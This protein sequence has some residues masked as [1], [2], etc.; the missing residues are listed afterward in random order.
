[1]NVLCQV[2]ITC[3][4]R[5]L[6]GGNGCRAQIGHSRYRSVRCCNRVVTGEVIATQTYDIGCGLIY[7]LGN[8]RHSAGVVN[9]TDHVRNL[10]KYIQR[11]TAYL[12]SGMTRIVVNENRQLNPL[13]SLLEMMNDAFL[14]WPTIVGLNDEYCVCTE[15]FSLNGSFAC[16]GSAVGASRC[17]DWNAPLVK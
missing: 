12:H 17:D 16:R 1:M 9:E 7:R 6:H 11:E 8:A 5:P 15:L 4:Y 3:P 14:T 2:C 10:Q 13:R